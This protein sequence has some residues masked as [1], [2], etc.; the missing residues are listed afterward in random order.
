MLITFPKEL[1]YAVYQY[2]FDKAAYLT[3]GSV[4]SLLARCCALMLD[5]RVSPSFAH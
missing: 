5:Q 2:G 4:T 3:T 1:V